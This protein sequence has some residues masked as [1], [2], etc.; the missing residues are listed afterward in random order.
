MLL[1]H[2]AW[3]LFTHR[4][5]ALESRAP[6]PMKLGT[7][8]AEGQ[9]P[10]SSLVTPIG[11]QPGPRDSLSAGPW[12]HST[13]GQSQPLVCFLGSS[14]SWAWKPE[15]QREDLYRKLGVGG[16]SWQAFH[17][18]WLLKLSLPLPGGRTIHAYIHPTDLASNPTY[19]PHDLSSNDELL[20]NGA[21]YT[22]WG[23]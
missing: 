11:P 2:V 1:G 14:S 15:E 22:N 10:P 9:I 6:Q 19:S 20:R 8:A 18:L 7:A 16:R 13:G 23:C 17:H 12:D 3:D 5:K 4:A 21:S